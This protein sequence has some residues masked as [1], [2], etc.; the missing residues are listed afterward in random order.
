MNLRLAIAAVALIATPAFAQPAPKNAPPQQQAAPKPTQA[1]VQKVVQ[2]VS[3]DKVKLAAYCRVSKLMEQMGTLDEKKDAKK[4]QDLGSQA[5]AESQKL[6]PE[7]SMVMEG[8]EQID[9]NSP[10]GKKI[11]AI[12]APLDA[13][14]K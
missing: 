11:A 12:L 10:E 8:L 3:A 6:G 5:D 9:E 7:F 2:A 4:L 1:Q 13:K 14:C